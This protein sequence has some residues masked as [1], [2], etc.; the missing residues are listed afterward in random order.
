MSAIKQPVRTRRLAHWKFAPL[1]VIL[2]GL[3][4]ACGSG[5]DDVDGDATASI[6]EASA[7]GRSTADSG[8]SGRP[9]NPGTGNA[10]NGVATTPSG[11]GQ[12]P[13]IA[14]PQAAAISDAEAASLSYMRE[15]ERLAHDVYAASNRYWG[16]PVFANIANSEAQHTAA[17]LLLLNRYVLPD[18]LA[19][20]SEGW[21][22]TPAFQTLHD[23]L[24]AR[25]ARS[26]V[27]ALIVGAEI[28]ELDMR[29]IVQQKAD[30]D[31]ADILVVYDNLLKGSRNHLRAFVGQLQAQGISYT[32]RLL[33][34]ADYEAIVGTPRETGP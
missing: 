33:S 10:G 19:G 34:Q 8:N 16:A 26:I 9:V 22:A 21:F 3:L 24:V 25:S 5:S 28:E 11:D 1:T 32:P 4:A 17:V 12:P 27:D 31:N 2:L 20:L 6:T 18:P 15:E 29:D 23:E 14:D 13:V 7:A 30:A